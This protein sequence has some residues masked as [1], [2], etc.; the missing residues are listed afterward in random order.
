MK[1]FMIFGLCIAG[2]ASMLGC[3]GSGSD[4]GA[5][6]TEKIK[7]AML[8]KVKG[9]A[10]FTSCAKGAQEAADELGNVEL[11]Y[12][13]PTTASADKQA[14]MIDK[15]R[16]QGVDVICLLYTSDAADE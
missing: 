2:V 7:V 11:I 4:E 8:P 15:W 1:K 13:G 10:Y 6:T 14:Q 9:I 12:N 3:G 5:G 16:L